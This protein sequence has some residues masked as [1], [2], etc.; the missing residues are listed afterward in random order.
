MILRSRD[1]LH[2]ED[3]C[4][5]SVMEPRLPLMISRT[6][7][8]TKIFGFKTLQVWEIKSRMFDFSSLPPFSLSRSGRGRSGGKSSLRA[9]AGGSVRRAEKKRAS[10]AQRASGKEREERGRKQQQQRQQASGASKDS[11]QSERGRETGEQAKQAGK[12]K[13]GPHGLIDRRL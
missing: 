6:R 12:R 13:K 7:P 9:R 8:A 11:E 5:C 1:I 4:R 3:P 10:G 2:A